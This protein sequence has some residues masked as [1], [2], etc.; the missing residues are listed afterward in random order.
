MNKIWKQSG[1][2]CVL[3]LGVIGLARAEGDKPA[4]A[5]TT[6]PAADEAAAIEAKFTEYLSTFKFPKD[7]DPDEVRTKHRAKQKEFS[8]L[9]GKLFDLK[10]AEFAVTDKA[11]ADGYVAKK[12]EIVKNNLDTGYKNRNKPFKWNFDAPPVDWKKK[13]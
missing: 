1:L 3:M 13:K 10:I 7:S 8:E 11:K 9:L 4:T 6:A 12:S 2:A 5:P